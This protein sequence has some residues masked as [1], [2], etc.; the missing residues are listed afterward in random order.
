MLKITLNEKFYYIILNIFLNF[1]NKIF[2]FGILFDNKFI[3]LFLN[4]LSNKIYC[5]KFIITYIQH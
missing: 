5:Y 4:I 1:H 3:L 2:F